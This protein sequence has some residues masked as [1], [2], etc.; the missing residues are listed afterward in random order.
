MHVRGEDRNWQER[1]QFMKHVRCTWHN[2]RMWN[3]CWHQLQA[4]QDSGGMHQ[5]PTHISYAQSIKLTP[6][7]RQG[8]LWFPLYWRNRHPGVQRAGCASSKSVSIRLCYRHQCWA[9]QHPFISQ[10]CLL[11]FNPMTALRMV[12][13]FRVFPNHASNTAEED[14]QT[15]LTEWWLTWSCTLKKPPPTLL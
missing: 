1:G 2:P 15:C 3:S 7:C 9:L 10:F 5:F 12:F 14:G 8:A 4:L 6:M 13:N 11:L